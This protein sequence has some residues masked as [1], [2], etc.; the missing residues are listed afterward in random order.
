MARFLI[1]IHSGPEAANKATLGLL[2][3]VEAARAGHAVTVFLAGDGVALLPP[4]VRARTEGLGTGSAA[5]HLQA[6]EALGAR[7][8]V[9]QRSTAARGLGPEAL[10]GLTAEPGTPALLVALA[11]E[12]ETVLCY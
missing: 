6:L 1:H 11:A 2:I 10:E 8:V 3:A 12:A 9:S 4:A 5:E 7:L